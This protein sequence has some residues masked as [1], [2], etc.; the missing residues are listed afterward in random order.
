MFV[1]KTKIM[2]LKFQAVMPLLWCNIFVFV[3]LNNLHAQ[4]FV[5]NDGLALTLQ[6]GLIATVEGAFTNQTRGADLGTIDNAGCK[7][8]TN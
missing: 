2:K 6:S 5:T 4:A 1:L 8:Q 7:Y 3:A